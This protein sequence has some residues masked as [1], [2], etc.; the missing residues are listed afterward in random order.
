MKLE[1]GDEVMVDMI[2]NNQDL[3]D[4]NTLRLIKILKAAS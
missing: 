3:D 1:H 4:R 2:K